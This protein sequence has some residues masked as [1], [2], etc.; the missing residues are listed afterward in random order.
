VTVTFKDSASDIVT[1][2]TGQT[3]GGVALVSGTNLFADFIYPFPSMSVHVM[4]Q[5]GGKPQPYLHPTSAALMS[6]TVDVLVYGP[7]GNPGHDA[8]ETLMLAVM[9][10]LQQR[11]PS[12]YISCLCSESYPRQSIEP[13]T[14]RVLLTASFELRY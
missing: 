7:A 9:G 6:P 8:A 11:A 5:N 4:G 3:L 12:G 14:G 13:D 2:L 10:Y 1:L